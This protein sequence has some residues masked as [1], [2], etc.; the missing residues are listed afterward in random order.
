M[1]SQGVPMIRAG[2]EIGHTQLGNN[3]AYCQDNQISW[4]NWENAD[5]QLLE[6]TRRLV[7]F[8]KRHPV[9]RRRKWFQGRQLYG[10]GIREIGWFK[11]DGGEMSE[12][13]WKMG[14][15]KSLGVYLNGTSLTSPD[16]MG[17][18]II[19]ATFYLIF[20]AHH[21]PLG[22]IVPGAEWGLQWTPV[23]DTYQTPSWRGGKSYR[24]GEAL[25]VEGR[26][27]LLLPKLH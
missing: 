8:R 9:F 12:D 21:H 24:A 22:F 1:L 18:A 10:S 16:A 3:N 23:L 11:P 14:F 25:R 20:N 19:D 27:L 26:S 13:D 5:Q 15:A 4:L 2:D 6:F 17:E 7:S